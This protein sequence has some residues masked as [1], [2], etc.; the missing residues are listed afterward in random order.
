MEQINTGIS[1]VNTV[2][3]KKYEF[4]KRPRKTLTRAE[5]RKRNVCLEMGKDLKGKLIT[6]R[7]APRAKL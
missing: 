5:D 2:L 1:E 3:E 7:Y 6:F 4:L